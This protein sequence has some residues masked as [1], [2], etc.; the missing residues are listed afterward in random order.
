MRRIKKIESYNN[1]FKKILI[2]IAGMP[3]AG[4]TRFADYLSNKLKIF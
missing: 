3:G 2:I 1:V 4:K